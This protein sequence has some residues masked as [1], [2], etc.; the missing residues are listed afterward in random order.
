[1]S[2]SAGLIWLS[3]RTQRAQESWQMLCVCKLFQW[4]PLALL[5][6]RI[7]L[8]ELSF[9]KKLCSNVFTWSQLYFQ[10]LD[11]IIFRFIP[12]GNDG[13]L[14]K[15]FDPD[16]LNKCKNSSTGALE[17]SNEH[18]R[19]PVCWNQIHAHVSFN[20]MPVAAHM[21]E[22]KEPLFR[23]AE[24]HQMLFSWCRWCNVWVE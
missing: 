14:H 15:A 10:P 23:T 22:E 5:H 9:Q 2:P 7:S 24:F 21:F 16:T 19:R 13:I 6:I 18:Y 17:S 11:N 20:W 1:M 12:S 4:S 8:F 3:P